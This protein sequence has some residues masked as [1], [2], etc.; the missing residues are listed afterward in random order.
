ML[1]YPSKHQLH[2]KSW[3]N[4][5]YS[6]LA[7][8][9]E[10][11][12]PQMNVQF[13]DAFVKCVPD[14][15]YTQQTT[16]VGSAKRSSRQKGL[17]QQDFLWM[18]GTPGAFA[19]LHEGN[20]EDRK[21][22]TAGSS[23]VDVCWRKVKY[24]KTI[25]AVFYPPSWKLLAHFGFVSS[26]DNQW[27]TCALKIQSNHQRYFNCHVHHHLLKYRPVFC[28]SIKCSSWKVRRLFKLSQKATGV[29]FW[30]NGLSSQSAF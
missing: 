23:I 29:S 8:W 16:L 21:L 5:I 19:F 13:T 12:T 26:A 9:A 11:I 27:I 15:F 2:L 28:L 6:C 18:A 25:A 24:V 7:P 14:I 20:L 1:W 30:M 10:Q 22:G 17:M 3:W 4:D